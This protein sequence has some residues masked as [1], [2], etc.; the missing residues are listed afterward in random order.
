MKTITELLALS[1]THTFFSWVLL[2]WV[3]ICQNLSSSMKQVPFP[4]L[5]SR[6]WRIPFK[7]LLVFVDDCIVGGGDSILDCGGVFS[8]T[9]FFKM[10]TVCGLI[11][12]M[13]LQCLP[14]R[15][16][17][18]EAREAAD[19]GRDDYINKKR[20]LHGYFMLYP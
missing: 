11:N 16:E 18:W 2:G 9:T 17:V 15:S 4:I 5:F 6:C 13:V 10:S 19:S 3:A 12:P 20:H 1:L 14:L 8:C 7:L